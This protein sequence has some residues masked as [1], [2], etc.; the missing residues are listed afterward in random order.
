MLTAAFIVLAIAVLLGAVLAFM[1]MREGA[2]VPPLSIGALHGFIALAGLGCLI[3]ALGG[4]A[5]GVSQGV[6][7][8]GM[9]AAALVTLAAALGLVMMAARRRGRQIAGALIGI[10]ATIAIGGFV[11]LLAY[12]LAG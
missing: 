11:V 12:V 7:S 2:V 10:H 4:P 6:G 5:R 8:F 3:L 1:H 9:L